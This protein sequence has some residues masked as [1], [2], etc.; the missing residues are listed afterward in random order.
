MRNFGRFPSIF[1]IAGLLTWTGAATLRAQVATESR[2]APTP[3]PE[4]AQVVRTEFM[5]ILQKYPPALGTVLKADPT[6]I[7]NDQYLAPYPAVASFL[8]QHPEVRRS[9]AYY[10]EQV[11]TYGSYY[12]DAEARA[13]NDMVEM[14]SVLVVTLT[15]LGA[16]GWFIRT[17]V[18]YRRWGRLAK[19]QAEAHTKLLDRFTGNEE[20]LAYVKSPAGTRFLESSPITLDGGT[21]PMGSP[22][23]RIMWSM[24][25]GIVLTTAGLGMNYLSRNIEPERADPVFALGVLLLSLGIGFVASAALSY[26]LSKRL[27]LLASETRESSN[28]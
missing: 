6:M 3:D 2:T 20:L 26:V 15:I 16:F 1:L 25:A 19:V 11:Q 7:T 18:D 22:V 28:A 14:L 17:A 21:R 23:S 13:W 12:Y 10:L 24:N 8:A 27:G 4:K 9:P 5:K